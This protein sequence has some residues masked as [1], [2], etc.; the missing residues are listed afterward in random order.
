MVGNPK[1]NV[2]R[3]MGALYQLTEII[4]VLAGPRASAGYLPD[5]KNSSTA[6]ARCNPPSCK[7]RRKTFPGSSSM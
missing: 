1:D 2:T 5:E 3:A 6:T 7:P 4:N